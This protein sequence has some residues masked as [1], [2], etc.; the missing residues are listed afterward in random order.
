MRHNVFR[1]VCI[2][3]SLLLLLVSVQYV[4]DLWPMAIV[5]A[6]QMQIGAVCLAIILL[7]A[8][9]VRHWYSLLLGTACVVLIAHPILALR[10]FAQAPEPGAVP[11]L[12]LLSIKIVDEKVD[13]VALGQAIDQ[14]NADILVVTSASSLASRRDLARQSYP[15][16]VGCDDPAS[17]RCT[18]MLLSRRPLADPRFQQLSPIGSELA[19]ASLSINGMRVRVFATRLSKMWFDTFHNFELFTITRTLRETREPVLLAGDFS[20]PVIV[21]DMR[22]FLGNNRLSSTYP[23]PATWP[24]SFGPLGISNDHIFFKAPFSVLSLKRTDERGQSGYIS[25]LSDVA[26]KTE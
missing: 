13:D 8:F 9:F 20:A 17:S 4:A 15:F 10:E 16:H 19:A 12:R 22:W 26:I 25:L 14:A 5:G 18:V 23:E 1:V 21:P 7:S 24:V 11:A 6:L 2:I 3:V